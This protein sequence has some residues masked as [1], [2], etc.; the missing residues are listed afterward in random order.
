MALRYES[1]DTNAPYL[2]DYA[3]VEFMP[4]ERR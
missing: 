4:N 2:L 3:L 1:N